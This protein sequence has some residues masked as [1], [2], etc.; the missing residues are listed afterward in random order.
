MSPVKGFNLT[1]ALLGVSARWGEP[2]GC[3]GGKAG[4]GGP[5]LPKDLGSLRS[6]D[7]GTLVR[8]ELLIFLLV[9]SA[10]AYQAI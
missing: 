3:G 6:R 5:T 2:G 7:W 1:P 4:L 10:M 8:I 9:P